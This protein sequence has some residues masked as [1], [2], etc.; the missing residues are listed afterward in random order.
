MEYYDP[1]E[2]IPRNSPLLVPRK[3]TL[4]G[5]TPSEP[6]DFDPKINPH[7]EPWELDNLL[8]NEFLSYP[9]VIA[10]PDSGSDDNI[11]SRKL[12]DQF[13]LQVMDIQHPAPSTFVLANGRTVSA[14][15]QVYLKF[16]MI[17]G[18][19]F[20][21]ATE[22][23]T[24]HGDRLVEELVPSIQ[25]LRV[26]SVGRSKRDVVC[27]VGNYVGCATA[28][29]GSDLDLV[30]PEFAASRVFDV[31]D[32][33]VELEFADGSTGYTIGMIKTA[34][35]IGRVSD[36]EGFIPRS[37]EMLLELYILDNL[38]ADILVGT[39]T[40]QDLQAFSGHEDCFI[41]AMPRLGESDLNIIRYIGA[42]E[43]GFSRAWEFLK[44]SFTSS[45]KKQATATS[46][47][48]SRTIFL[49]LS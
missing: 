18:I 41:P 40:I 29:T 4:D 33:C 10:C 44:D 47:S 31:E 34:F 39:D 48:S 43:R 13:G 36:V 16:P 26:C 24:K 7:Y 46:M 11:M 35:S 45:E 49:H 32:S 17:M 5:P 37:K 21:Q 27:R 23:L 3:L 42:V 12:A 2:V 8:E 1:D 30:S 38:N 20:L 6:W 15:G 28:D 9:S 19:E 14:V 25:A 22:T